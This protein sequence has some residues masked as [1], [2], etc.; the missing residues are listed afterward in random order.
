MRTKFNANLL[1]YYCDDYFVDTNHVHPLSH[2]VNSQGVRVY[3]TVI[4]ENN[5]H[6]AFRR[7]FFSSPEDDVVMSVELFAQLLDRLRRLCGFEGWLIN[8]EVYAP[9]RSKVTTI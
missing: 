7:I 2:P 1:Y 6:E 4:M 9:H 5:D 3:G 8:F